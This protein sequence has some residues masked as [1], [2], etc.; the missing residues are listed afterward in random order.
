MA[1]ITLYPHTAAAEQ[2][3]EPRPRRGVALRAGLRVRGRDCRRAELGRGHRDVEAQPRRAHGPSNTL[4]S[5]PDSAQFPSTFLERASSWTGAHAGWVHRL[6]FD[7]SARSSVDLNAVRTS[8]HTQRLT[9]HVPAHGGA[10]LGVP[11]PRRDDGVQTP[12]DQGRQRDA[13]A[14]LR[15]VRAPPAPA[16]AAS[17]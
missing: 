12:R 11:Q 7:D 1:T 10:R 2:P 8:G 13:Q 4:G 17:H 9:G 14:A 6:V 3:P 5:L 15:E 16:A